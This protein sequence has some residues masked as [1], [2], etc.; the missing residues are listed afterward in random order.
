MAE[1]AKPIVVLDTNLYVSYLITP[2]GPTARLVELGLAPRVDGNL[3]SRLPKAQGDR[4]TN[5]AAGAGH[6]RCLLLVHG[7]ASL[8]WTKALCS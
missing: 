7:S 5:P 6:Q 1:P 4:T 8:G 3:P 2:S